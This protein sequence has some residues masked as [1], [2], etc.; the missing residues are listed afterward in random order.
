MARPLRVGGGSKGLATKKNTVFWSSY[1]KFWENFVATKLEGGGGGK[2]LGAGPLKN[3]VFCGLPK[4]TWVVEETWTFGNFFSFYV[5]Q[6]AASSRFS[7]TRYTC[8]PIF[9]IP[10]KFK[11]P[12][13]RNQKAGN[14][15]L[16]HRQARRR[17]A[18]LRLLD[19]HAPYCFFIHM[20]GIHKIG[21]KWCVVFMSINMIY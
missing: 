18:I 14:I 7:M 17:P 12:G 1:I 3:I 6:E 15:A 19:S 5:L 9:K 11:C 8:A 13:Y 21:G 4:L 20:C 10:S 16:V 2:A